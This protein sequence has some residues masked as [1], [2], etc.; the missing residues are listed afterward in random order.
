MTSKAF[1]KATR[2]KKVICEAAMG[3]S[4]SSDRSTSRGSLKKRA[5]NRANLD[6]D[7][8]KSLERK[9][10]SRPI[11]KSI[12]IALEDMKSSR[13]YFE[14][15]RTELRSSLVKITFADHQGSDP[16]NVVEAAKK[17]NADPEDKFDEVWVVFDTE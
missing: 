10:D 14:D 4:H 5:R 3:Q 16:K 15:F 9:G 13:L 7:L 11:R 1:E 17:A 8:K 6:P 12:L 2:S